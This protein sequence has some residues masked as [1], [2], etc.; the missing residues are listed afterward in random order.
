VPSSALCRDSVPTVQPRASTPNLNQSLPARPPAVEDRRRPRYP[1]RHHATAETPTARRPDGP[2]PAARSGAGV[3]R[4]SPSR[5]RP[6]P[7]PAE[8]DRRTS[9]ARRP[10]RRSPHRRPDPEHCGHGPPLLSSRATVSR[11]EQG[12]V[13]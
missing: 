1:P 3:H 10:Q 7:P 9:G 13:I 11:A 8:P 5:W 4:C 6:E 12:F 2:T